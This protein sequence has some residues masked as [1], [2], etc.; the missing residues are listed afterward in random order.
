MTCWIEPAPLPSTQVLLAGATQFTVTLAASAQLAAGSPSEAVSVTVTVPA[1]VQVKR[2]LAVAASVRVPPD[3]VQ[4]SAS[5]EGP[6]SASWAAPSSAI[7][8]PTCTC[9]GRALT[10]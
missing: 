5:G 2:G 6:M 4:C 3:T 7:D 1:L 10:P 9:A 8:P